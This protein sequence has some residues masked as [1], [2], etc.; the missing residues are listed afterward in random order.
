MTT[1]IELLRPP[2]LVSSPAFSHVAVLPPN[3]TQI[4]VG[5]QNGVDGAGRLVGDDV[6]AQVEQTMANLQAALEAAGATMADLVSLT[7]LLVDGVD[8]LAGYQAAAR[9]LTTGDGAP[10]VTAAIVRALAVPGA[11]V[12]VSAVAA[13]LR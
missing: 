10:L 1:S 8:L 4:L 3:A 9:R 2:G 11:L 6:V 7:V 5:G 13:V 12:E